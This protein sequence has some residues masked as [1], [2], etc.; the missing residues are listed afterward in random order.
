[1]GSLQPHHFRCQDGRDSHLTVRSLSVNISFARIKVQNKEQC[2]SLDSHVASDK[3]VSA[4]AQQSSVLHVI[5][6]KRLP[7]VGEMN[8][9]VA[10]CKQSKYFLSS[11]IFAHSGIF[12]MP[13]LKKL[14]RASQAPVIPAPLYKTEQLNHLVFSAFCRCVNSKNS[15]PLFH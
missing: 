12:C 3:S 5:T 10:S 14:D 8:D 13:V 11:I 4:S 9:V 6:I 7:Q 1:M 15:P 2:I